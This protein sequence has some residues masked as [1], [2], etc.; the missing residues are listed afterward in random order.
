LIIF[1]VDASGSMAAQR[2]MEA[3]KGAVLN[4]L[5][6]AYQQRDE[7]AVVAFRGQEA[8]LLLA[9]TR[10]VDLAER[11]LRE[12]PTGGRTPL[13]HALQMALDVVERAKVASVSGAPLLVLMTD[14]KANV[15]LADS[16]DPW[17]ESLDLAEVLAER[18][19]PSLVIDTE[20]GYTRFG[21][22]A[23]LAEALRSECLTLED[24]SADKLALTV[25]VR[26]AGA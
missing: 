12:L 23:R 13:P 19:I 15:A 2:R 24:L 11:N 16:G 10:S 22:A 9:P 7:V 6:D 25:R 5:T 21:R 1:V 3:L 4:L 14:G 17:R 18:R 8:Q 20:S 26:L